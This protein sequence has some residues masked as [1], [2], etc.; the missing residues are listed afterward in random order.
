MKKH[1]TTRLNSCIIDLCVRDSAYTKDKR[2]MKYRLSSEHF[3]SIAKQARVIPTYWAI[4]EIC[5]DNDRT[6][7]S[8]SQED[9]VE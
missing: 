3:N 5:L 2:H 4:P 8:G 1:L 7:R 9:S 6:G